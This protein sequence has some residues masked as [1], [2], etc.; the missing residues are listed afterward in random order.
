[1]KTKK[2]LS[3][4]FIS[5]KMPLHQKSQVPLLINGNGEII[6]V[7]G[8]RLDDRYKVTKNTKKVTIFELYKVS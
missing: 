5:L 4:F 1:M 6:W 2:K 7:G 3:D 8:A